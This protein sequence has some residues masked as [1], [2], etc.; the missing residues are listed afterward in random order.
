MHFGWVL[1][2]FGPTDKENQVKMYKSTVLGTLP[3]WT[4]KD[5]D[6]YQSEKQDPDPYKTVWICNP[7][8]H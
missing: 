3:P 1:L 5:P 8:S 6:P 7:G 4:G 2:D